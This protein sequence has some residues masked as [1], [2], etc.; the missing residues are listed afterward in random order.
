MTSVPVRHL[1]RFRKAFN[2][3][4][5]IQAKRPAPDDAVDENRAQDHD[6]MTASVEEIEDIIE[7]EVVNWAQ[8]DI[9]ADIN[10]CPIH[11]HSTTT[12]L[13]DTYRTKKKK[14]KKGLNRTH[15][16]LPEIC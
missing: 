6:L 9:E 12:I 14:K 15:Q 2:Q 8:Q 5:Q 7:S 10:V 4:H 13:N 3:F 16:K 1:I 11:L